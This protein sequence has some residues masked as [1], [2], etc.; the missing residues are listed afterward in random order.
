MTL[1]YFSENVYV[2]SAGEINI[3]APLYGT[4]KFQLTRNGRTLLITT[5]TERLIAQCKLMFSIFLI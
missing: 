2:S 1:N 4:A 3:L 5:L